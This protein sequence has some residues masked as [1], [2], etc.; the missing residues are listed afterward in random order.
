MTDIAGWMK[1]VEARFRDMDRRLRNV[2]GTQWQNFSVGTN[3]AILWSNVTARFSMD[4]PTVHVFFKGSYAGYYNATLPIYFNLPLTPRAWY[5]KD[6]IVGTGIY[7]NPGVMR[8]ALLV[9]M[10]ADGVPDGTVTFWKDMTNNSW[11]TANNAP[12]GAMSGDEFMTAQFSY[13]AIIQ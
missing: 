13:E 2:N 4:G 8:S 1:S 7:H 11:L 3:N 6:T 12:G 9:G 10:G 5:T